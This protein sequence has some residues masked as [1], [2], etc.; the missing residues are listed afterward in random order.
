MGKLGA[1]LGAMAMTRMK[2]DPS[3]VRIYGFFPK[4]I[5]FSLPS[6]SYVCGP[7]VFGGFSMFVARCG[8]MF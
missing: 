2:D 4:Q 5:F 3:L 8:G 6:A 1:V 7:F